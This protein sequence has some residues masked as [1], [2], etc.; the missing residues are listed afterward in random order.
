MNLCEEAGV[1]LCFLT[2]YSPDL[3]P[4]EEM[5]NVFKTWTKSNAQIID[6]FPEFSDF[7]GMPQKRTR[8]AGMKKQY[9]ILSVFAY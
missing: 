8:T 7:P 3:N 5:F 9:L 4:I 6:I 1:R 2:P